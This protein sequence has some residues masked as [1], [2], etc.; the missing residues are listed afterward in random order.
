MV[1][2]MLEIHNLTVEAE[3]KEILNNIN[4]EIHPGETHV[5]MG[6][7]GAGKST[8]C[9]ALMSYPGLVKSGV[10][11]WN[12][13]EIIDC[14]PDVIA[15]KGIYYIAQNPIAIEGVTTAEL[16]RSSLNEH[17]ITKDIFAFNKECTLYC[18]KLEMPKNFL[19]RDINV[20]LSG[21]ERKKNE[22]L[23]MWLL[24]P[25]LVILD[26]IDSGLDVDAIKVVA[27]NIQEYQKESNCAILLVS[28]Q[29]ELLKL[30]TPDYV[31]IM[32]NKQIICN[33]DISLA[34]DILKQG[35]KNISG[36]NEV[37]NRKNEE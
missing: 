5:L 14:S 37:I 1:M 31:H 23:G 36:T 16:Y 30:L 12:D 21:G 28:H 2:R 18:E 25:R 6:P 15:K 9:K 4:L 22:L 13:E 20:S 10:V 8:L 29:S 19:H 7:N 34:W 24:K 33:G 11:K 3:K 17:Q 35:F 32:M 26:E 27:K